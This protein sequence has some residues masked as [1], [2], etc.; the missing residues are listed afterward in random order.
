[1]EYTLLTT[2]FIVMTRMLNIIELI[3]MVVD[4]LLTSMFSRN[5]SKLQI[6]T[7][8]FLEF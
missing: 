3:G 1:M 7:Q 8:N 6:I 2:T 5:N 4:R